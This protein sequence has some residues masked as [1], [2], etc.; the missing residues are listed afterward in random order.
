M[1]GHKVNRDNPI[2]RYVSTCTSEYTSE[3]I[4]KNYGQSWELKLEDCNLCQSHANS[5]NLQL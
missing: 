2:E 1:Q 4:A 3:I 5:A